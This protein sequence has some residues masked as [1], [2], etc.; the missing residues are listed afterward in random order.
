MRKKNEPW[1]IDVGAM[2]D[3]QSNYL[4]I[5]SSTCCM[6]WQDAVKNRIDWLAMVKSV[7]YEAEV[8]GS[9][10]RVQAETGDWNNEN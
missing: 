10:S 2:I 7:F 8:P 4:N 9:S 1:S 5:P 3:E 6:Q